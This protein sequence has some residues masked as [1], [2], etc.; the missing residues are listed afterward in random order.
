MIIL[1]LYFFL[2]ILA[3][4][5]RGEPVYNKSLNSVVETHDR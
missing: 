4:W 3:S 2:L 5:I 1:N